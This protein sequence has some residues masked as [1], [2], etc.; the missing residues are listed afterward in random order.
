MLAALTVGGGRK[1]RS[2][3]LPVQLCYVD[4]AGD[5][6]VYSSGQPD[7][8]PVFAL[9]GLSIPLSK[10]DNLIWEFLELKKR[11]HPHLKRGQLS[12]LLSFEYKGSTVR[13]E[14]RSGSRRQRRRA[15]GF[16]DGVMELLESHQVSLFGDLL[17]KAEG[18]DNAP[19]RLYA[20]AVAFI[21]ESFNSLLAAGRLTGLMVLDSRTKAKN[22]GNVN[23]IT[24]RRYK[25]GS[26][27]L[28]RLAESP[29]FGHSDTHVALQIVDV[30]TSGLIIPIACWVYCLS[31]SNNANV[32]EGYAGL[33]ERFGARLQNLEYRY[34]SADGSR[35]GGLR[36]RDEICHRPTHL[37]F[38]EDQIFEDLSRNQGPEPRRAILG[39]DIGAATESLQPQLDILD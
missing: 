22:A 3:S 16:L 19:H 36:L 35:R 7:Q 39:Q 11:F 20:D 21:A 29:V 4:E 10:Q 23:A 15:V 25:A 5:E 31:H 8:L 14:L 27:Q 9:I 26:N 37:L 6:T 13:K 1:L 33:R 12:S 24:T 2:E 18:K 38:R 17:I 28:G 32:N 30:L 34:S